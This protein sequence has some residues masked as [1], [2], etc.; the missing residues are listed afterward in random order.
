MLDSLQGVHPAWASPQ[1]ML[2]LKSGWPQVTEAASGCVAV[3]LN[4]A[5]RVC[6]FQMRLAKI[7]GQN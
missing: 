5:T 3:P 6:F 7:D 1:G 2:M 4:V